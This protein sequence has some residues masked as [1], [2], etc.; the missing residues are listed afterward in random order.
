[1]LFT[2]KPP[3]QR[4]SPDSDC[5]AHACVTP[6][7]RLL[8]PAQST[9]CRLKIPLQ[10]KGLA[11]VAWVLGWEA[12]PCALLLQRSQRLFTAS[13]D[14]SVCVMQDVVAWRRR[15]AYLQESSPWL[16]MQSLALYAWATCACVHA[17]TLELEWMGRKVSAA[18]LQNPRQAGHSLQQDTRL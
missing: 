6:A 8:H 7:I 16:C 2:C 18:G 15:V 13:A 4:L 14:C 10:D 11:V 5:H 17:L 3:V 9:T 1:M 12:A